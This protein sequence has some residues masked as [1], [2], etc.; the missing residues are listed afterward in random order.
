M[1]DKNRAFNEM[2]V[3]GKNRL[4]GRNPVDIS[5]KARVEFCEDTQSF[6]VKSLDKTVE[7]SYPSYE[8][9]ETVDKWY[10]LIFATLSGYCRW[11]GCLS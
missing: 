6:K 10:I 3:V 5:E 8:C 2:Y 11:E 4:K 7:L 9:R 1:E